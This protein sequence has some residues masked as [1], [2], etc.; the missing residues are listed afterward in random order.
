MDARV[1]GLVP[2]LEAAGPEMD[3]S[4][5][6]TFLNDLALFA[7]ARLLE[8]D[9]EWIARS[10]RRVDIR[11]QH[12]GHTVEAELHFD[13]LEDFRSDDRLGS[14]DH[15]FETA[16]WRTPVRSRRPTSPGLLLPREAEAWWNTDAGSWCYARFTVLDVETWNP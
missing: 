12:L 7:P 16:R 5:T 3:R 9:L 4:E 15:G 14:T 10:S 2:I 11:W 8:L 13:G 1:L 6:V